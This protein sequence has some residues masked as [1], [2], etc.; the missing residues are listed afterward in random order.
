LLA[1][2][3]E[4]YLAAMGHGQPEAH[5]ERQRFVADRAIPLQALQLPRESIK[6]PSDR[7]LTPIRGVGRQKGRDRRLNDR[8][9][10]DL[11]AQC[12]C[13]HLRQQP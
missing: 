13:I 1:L 6:A 9:L 5:E 7:G 11:L 3:P 4:P 8:R 10:R 12:E 2:R